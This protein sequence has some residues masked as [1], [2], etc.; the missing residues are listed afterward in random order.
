MCINY[1]VCVYV[2]VTLAALALAGKRFIRLASCFSST[3]SLP[4]T[5]GL[6][7]ES[8]L[9]EVNGS[10]VLVDDGKIE[11]VQEL[12]YLGSKL[13]CDREITPEGSCHIARASKAYG[14]LRVL[15]FLN[16]ILSSDTKR[17]V[18]K[19]FMVSILLYG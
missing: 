5:K 13:S 19:A 6:A 11:M 16:C 4:K 1:S 3:F 15:V 18:Y 8:A 2:C 14:C 12:T 10:P 9:S 7:V 17:A